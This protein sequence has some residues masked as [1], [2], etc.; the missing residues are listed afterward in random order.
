MVLYLPILAI[1]RVN[2]PAR[3]HRL[4]YTFIDTCLS[5]QW[6]K[7]WKNLKS[8]HTSLHTI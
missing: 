3:V 5:K 1:L 4:S 2:L 7:Q 8:D 6:L